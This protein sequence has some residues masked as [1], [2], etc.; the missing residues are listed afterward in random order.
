MANRDVQREK[1]WFKQV[2]KA[3]FQQLK[4]DL[5]EDTWLAPGSAPSVPTETNSDGWMYGLGSVRGDRGSQLE[6][7][8]DRWSGSESRMLCYCYRSTSGDRVEAMAKVGTGGLG[9]AHH[10]KNSYAARVDGTAYNTMKTPLKKALYGR[11]LVEVTDRPG[12][13]SFLGVYDASTPRLNFDPPAALVS[14]ASN[15]LTEAAVA[16]RALTRAARSDQPFPEARNRSQVKLHVRRE[17]SAIQAA[18]AKQRDKY[19]CRVCDLTFEARYGV[20]GSRYAE[21]HHVQQLSRL[22]EG[23]KIS[24]DDLI[25]VCANCHRM[26]H[27]ME[28]DAG[29]WLSLRKTVRRLRR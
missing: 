11:P 16:A 21:A 8:F 4:G 29:D 23:T 10:F 24:V 12:Y 1:I 25:C 17:R 28:G 14:R 13:A 26:L 19:T 18:L 27:R 22:R 5:V 6:L 20:L 3:V 2:A 15:F 9:V 7:W